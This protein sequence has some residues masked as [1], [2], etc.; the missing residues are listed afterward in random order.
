MFLASSNFLELLMAG[1]K[2]L[3]PGGF[4]VPGFLKLYVM[5]E[6]LVHWQGYCIALGYR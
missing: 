6:A 3:K 4:S 5:A 2:S 1:E